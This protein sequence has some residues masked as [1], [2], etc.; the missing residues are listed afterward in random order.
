M[1]THP[2]SPLTQEEIETV[3]PWLRRNW[4]SRR[5]FSSVNLI[6]PKKAIVLNH[7]AGDSVQR[8][9]RFVGYDYPA[10]GQRDGGFEGIVD[11]GTK[12]VEINRIESGHAAIGIADFVQAIQI[13]KADPG[14]QAAM[15]LRG[16]TDF[17]LVQIDPCQ[18]AVTSIRVFRWGIAFTVRSVL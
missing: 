11:L 5:P 2:L 6:E 14:W 8:R 15:R 10:Q 7:K 12:A 4:E 1:A 3:Q 18:A 17:D 13:T 16:V 9:L